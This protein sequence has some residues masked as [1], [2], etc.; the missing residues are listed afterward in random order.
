MAVPCRRFNGQ[1]NV[2]RA[3]VD[4]GL[5][6]NGLTRVKVRQPSAHSLSE[7]G[8]EQRGSPGL[9][10]VR[11]SPDARALAWGLA[12]VS[13]DEAGEK[14]LAALVRRPLTDPQSVVQGDPSPPLE[15]SWHPSMGWKR[16]PHHLSKESLWERIREEAREDA[17]AE[18]TLASILHSTVLVHKTFEKTMAFVLANKLASSTLLGIHLMRLCQEAYEK[19]EDVI[20]AGIADLQA[21]FD[22]DPACDKYTQC[23]LYFKGFQAL[24]SH[25]IAHWLWQRG[26]KALALAVQSRSSEVF[27]VDI[28][29]AA[30]IGRGVMIDHATGVVVGESAVIGDNVSMLHHV[31][32]GGSGTG[33][34]LR[35]PNIGHG[36][37]LGA[38]VSV[39][40]PICIGNGTKVGAGAVVVSDMP[41]HAVAVGVPAKIVKLDKKCEPCRNMDQCS[42]FILNYEI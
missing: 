10:S 29:P 3:L 20:E 19:D 39:L 41:P 5:R 17:E 4:E 25:R 36:V 14:R 27:H 1:T 40:G 37:L 18:P 13:D 26:R 12:N 35:H 15:T 24:Q 30:T 7:L 2:G 16:M 8:R 28:H 21:V 22:R 11:A 6:C 31:T 42:D 9:W 32:L 34:G 38:G 23:M 33:R